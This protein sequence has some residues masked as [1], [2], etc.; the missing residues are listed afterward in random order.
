ME[1]QPIETG[2]KDGR[3]VLLWV[4]DLTQNVYIGRWRDEEHLSFGKVQRSYKEWCYTIAFA[5]ENL[6]EPTHWAEIPDGPKGFV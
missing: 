5:G 6:P 4:P 3:T 1:W 2:P